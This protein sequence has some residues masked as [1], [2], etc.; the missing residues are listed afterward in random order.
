ML[1]TAG[2]ASN[3]TPGADDQLDGSTGTAMASGFVCSA[4]DEDLG[5][6]GTLRGRSGVYRLILVL[7]SSDAVQRSTEGELWLRSQPPG[8][9]DFAG[10][11]TR[12]IGSTDIAVE[13][14]DAFRVGDPASEDPDAPGVRD[15]PDGRSILLR[16][17]SDATVGTCSL[18]TAPT[19]S[20]WSDESTVA[21]SP[22]AGEAPPGTNVR[23]ATSALGVAASSLRQFLMR[24]VAYVG[25]TVLDSET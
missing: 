21:A 18:S 15:G 3:P 9:R 17:G 11:P 4:V 5:P 7:N 23:R 14:V 24:E 12:L 10:A 16:L 22:G 25:P 1:L 20:W 19:R 13:A 8:S 6:D 2:C